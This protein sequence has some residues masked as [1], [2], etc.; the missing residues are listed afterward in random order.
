MERKI[1][2]LNS[3]EKQPEEPRKGNKRDKEVLKIEGYPVEGLSIAG[4]ETCVIFPSLNLAFDIGRCPQR[5]ISQDFLFISHGHMDHIGGLPMYVATRGLYRMKP[6]TIFVPTAIKED[7]EK[8]FEVHRK[9]DGSELNHNLV[10]LDWG[11]EFHLRKDLKV[12]AFKTY[13]VIQSQGYLVSSV[14]HKLKQEYLGL[15]GNEIKNLKTSGVEITYT[16]TTPEIAF[17]GD[18]M[19][20]FII[21]QT[22]VDVLKARILVLESTFVDSSV[23]V[24]QARDYG[25]THLSEIVNYAE[26]LENQAILLIHF[27]ARYA[28]EEIQKAVSMLPPPLAGRVFALTEG[29]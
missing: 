12:R 10:G 19:S 7:V 20:D 27:S 17:T 1:K 11:E 21:D 5:A 16:I 18:T 9:M 29:F 8:L 26:R 22:N 23:S 28:L 6:P 13:H 24:E 2:N 25:H 14:K 3:E 4:H 15:S